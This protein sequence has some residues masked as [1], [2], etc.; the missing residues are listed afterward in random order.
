MEACCQGKEMKIFQ[1]GKAAPKVACTLNFPQTGEKTLKEVMGLLSTI[2]LSGLMPS[3]KASPHHAVSIE[4]KDFELKFELSWSGKRGGFQIWVFF[5]KSPL[6]Y[7]AVTAQIDSAFH[8]TAH[9]YPKEAAVLLKK[10]NSY[11]RRL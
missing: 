11:S 6:S 5:D 2:G 1:V 7:E 9:S 3:K 4:M 8:V 10:T